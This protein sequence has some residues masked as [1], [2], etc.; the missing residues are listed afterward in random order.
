M[1]QK[2]TLSGISGFHH[3]FMGA[4]EK[5][6]LMKFV[7]IAEKNG[8][9][10]A[11]II[12]DGQRIPGK[13]FF[14]QHWSREEVISK[15]YEAYENFIK[16]GVIPELGNDGKYKIR[17][18]TNERIKIEMHITQKGHIKSAYPIIKEGL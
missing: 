17:A 16:S 5:S 11:D 7:R 15:I 1:M 12:V 10:M 3:D 9:Y 18:L 14:P 8:C 4:V 6:G 2:N 13:T